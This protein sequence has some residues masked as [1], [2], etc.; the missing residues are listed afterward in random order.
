MP[1]LSDDA[2]WEVADQGPEGEE[3]VGACQK[4]PLVSIGAVDATRRDFAAAQGEARAVQVV[5]RF[6]DGKSAWRAQQVLVAWR[7]DCE[8]RLEYARREVGPMQEVPVAT[9]IGASYRASYGPKP[10][11]R[12]VRSS[13]GIV[14]KGSYLS[15]VEIASPPAEWPTVGDPARAAVRRIART[16]A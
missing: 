11:A 1:T 12:G 8:E 4:T 9:G 7:D 6:A 15:I 14:R 10:E 2:G 13:F 3:A 5:G 16:F